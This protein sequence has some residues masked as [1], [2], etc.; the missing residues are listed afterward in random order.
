LW[1]INSLSNPRPTLETYRYGMPGEV[2][3]PQADLEVFDIASKARV[4][5]KEDRF[6]DQ[7]VALYTAVPT[8]AER[9]RAR[10][11]SS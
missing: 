3:Q 10:F 9:E 7:Q 8:N 11:H 1:V 2:N 6:P 5:I 4:K